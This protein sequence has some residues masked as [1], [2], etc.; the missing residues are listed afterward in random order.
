MTTKAAIFAL[1]SLWGVGTVA[2]LP[3]V[4][5]DTPV[6]TETADDDTDDLGRHVGPGFMLGDASPV[7][8]AEDR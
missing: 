2:C 5:R 8:L 6:T 3:A 7:R 1:L 4:A